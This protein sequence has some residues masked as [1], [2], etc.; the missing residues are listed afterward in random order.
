VAEANRLSRQLG[1]R[2]AHFLHTNAHTALRPLC[3]SLSPAP[4]RT[5][6]IFHPD[7]CFKE[8]HKKRRVVTPRFVADIAECTAQGGL[9]VKPVSEKVPSRT[10]TSTAKRDDG[11]RQH[12]H[13]HGQHQKHG[14]RETDGDADVDTVRTGAV[15]WGREMEK[16]RAGGRE[17]GREAQ[18]ETER[19]REREKE[20]VADAGNRDH[21]VDEYSLVLTAPCL[22]HTY[23]SNRMAVTLSRVAGSDGGSST[24]GHSASLSKRGRTVS[25]TTAHPERE[26]TPKAHSCELLRTIRKVT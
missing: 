5:T 3:A 19:E 12:G 17:G 18:R 22:H 8:S 7:P 16:G 21:Y 26:T 23:Q 13:R 1:L 9:K 2:N 11:Q 10:I 14:H 6:T 24:Q 4:L 15:I 25:S 20:R